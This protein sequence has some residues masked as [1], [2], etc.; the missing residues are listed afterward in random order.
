MGLKTRAKLKK[1]KEKVRFCAIFLECFL[2]LYFLCFK[3]F[4]SVNHITS[5]GILD[6]LP[7]QLYASTWIHWRTE[8]N[9]SQPTAWVL[10]GWCPVYE[11]TWQ[12]SFS[13]S[14]LAL[15]VRDVQRWKPKCTMLPCASTQ[16]HYS[17]HNSLHNSLLIYFNT[18]LW[19]W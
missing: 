9:C 12:K 18:H 8:L 7:A 14:F 4:H 13:Q 11:S 6:F 19:T 15:M 16:S 2:F 10:P 3:S 17:C 5:T 1:E